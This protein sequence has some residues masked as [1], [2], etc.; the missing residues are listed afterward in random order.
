[1]N[2]LPSDP[3][4]LLSVINMKL[5]DQYD[6]LDSLCDD[7]DVNKEEIINKLSSVNYVYDETQNQFK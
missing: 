2:T 4:M 5:R 1:M 3:I 7:L 6:S